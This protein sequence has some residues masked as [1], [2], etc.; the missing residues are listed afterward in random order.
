MNGSTVPEYKDIQDFEER[1]STKWQIIIKLLKAI[2]RN[3]AGPFPYADDNNNLVIPDVEEE[4]P[5]ARCKV[6]IF[7]QFVKTLPVLHSA[8]KVH[9][10][11]YLEC[12]GSMSPKKRAEMLRMF[13]DH[14]ANHRI[15]ILSNVGI[16]GLNLHAAQHLIFADVGWTG[17]DRTQV[18]GRLQRKP[19]KSL[20]HVY[21]PCIN[22]TTDDILNGMSLTK[23]RLLDIFL[24]ELV[25]S[26]VRHV[27][28]Y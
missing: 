13:A 26:G 27:P 24:G 5:E 3:D 11:D 17:Q 22:N 1:C 2:M 9:G 16:I 20:V 25:R 23:E 8:L 4:D 28:S 12:K 21:L 15:L 10:F 7:V 19:Q 14:G 6:V 18:I